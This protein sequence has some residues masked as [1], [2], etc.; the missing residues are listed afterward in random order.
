LCP[1]EK[2]EKSLFL[3]YVDQ[4][5]FCRFAGE[6][7]LLD[8]AGT[9]LLHTARVLLSEGQVL[10]RGAGSIT[11][12]VDIIMVSGG[13]SPNLR[14]GADEPGARGEDA[15]GHEYLQHAI[16]QPQP[17]GQWHA[18]PWQGMG[19]PPHQAYSP[20]QGQMPTM[21][22]NY[23]I[24]S[25]IMGPGYQ[26][27]QRTNQMHMHMPMQGQPTQ[28]MSPWGAGGAMYSSPS[29]VQLQRRAPMIDLDDPKMQ[30]RALL[31]YERAMERRMPWWGRDGR[32]PRG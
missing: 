13:T 5:L 25:G 4:R 27:P 16:Q 10:V 24:N 7:S 21:T 19:S 6:A 26:M 15:Q 12:G 31:A 23:G 22:Y 30:E 9:S 32:H 29:T 28:Q 14:G 17:V 2:W 3:Q 8:H 1:G 20:Y 18:A 11:T